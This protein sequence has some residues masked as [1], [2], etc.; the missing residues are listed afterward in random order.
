M[1][2]VV[3]TSHCDM[4]MRSNN[5]EWLPWLHEKGYEGAS[6]DFS[7]PGRNREIIKEYWRESV[8]QNRQFECCY[9]LG[10]R[11]IHDSGFNTEAFEKMPEDERQ[12]AQIGLL[13][14]VIDTQ[15]R[16]LRDVVGHPVMKIFVP[17]K[18]V[19]PLYDNGLKVPD[20]ITIVWANDNYGYVRRYPDETERVRSGGNGLY[21]HNSY[22]APPGASYTFLCSIPL[23]HTKNELRKAYEKGI[24]KLWVTNFGAIKP[25][26]M[27]ISFY[28][29]Y[30]WDI[31]KKRT[32]AY[33]AREQ[34]T[35]SGG[36][37]SLTE[38][39]QEW[40]A[41][42]IDRTF[43][44]AHGQVLAPILTAF[45]Q[46]TNTRKIEQMDDDAFSQTAYGNEAAMRIHLYEEWM[47]TAGAIFQSLPANERDAFYQ[48]VLMKIHAAYLTSL[49]YYYSDR[50]RL[51]LERGHNK[52]ALEACRS[53][54]EA[55]YARR[56]LFKYYN[57]VM[58]DGK[59]D[60]ILTPED[61]PPPRT[62][63]YPAC[64]PP[65]D[66]VEGD[67]DKC[68][69][70][71]ADY[72]CQGSRITLEAADG[73]ESINKNEP[74]PNCM[75]QSLK[76]WRII[77]Y[78]GRGRGSLAEATGE[79]GSLQYAFTLETDCAPL[80]ELHRF[81]S[82]NSVGRIYAEAAVDEE[83]PFTLESTATDEHR[84]SW[85]RN[86]RLGVDKLYVKLPHLKK[87]RHVLKIFG[88]S[89]YFAFSRI[90]LY[91]SERLE[92][93]LGYIE[94]DDSPVYAF[95]GHEF[96]RKWYGEECLSLTPRPVIIQDP[97][98][99]KDSTEAHDRYCLPKENAEPENIWRAHS[100]EE[101][102]RVEN[103]WKDRSDEEIVNFYQELIRTGSVPARETD[104]RILIETCAALGETENASYGNGEWTYCVSPAHQGRGLAMYIRGAFRTF[105]ED[106]SA[107]YLSFKIR[108]EG[109]Q[110]VIWLSVMTW[111]G[112]TD[113]FT[114]SVDGH[115]IPRD[116]LNEGRPLW[117]YS[118]E[119]VYKW[120]PVYE[121][122]LEKGIHELR[123]HTFATGMRIDQI[124]LQ[125]IENQ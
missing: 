97:R 6:Y 99:G 114:I 25:L 20:D 47:R 19:L 92:N 76:G 51:L 69:K 81:P 124:C 1:G 82:L 55:G 18:E 117:S 37:T 106:S 113:L 17:Y 46:L 43:S 42:W 70:T 120:I 102:I 119:Q 95:D 52:Q 4:L 90:V 78:T 63:M 38:D 112:N 118:G 39:V 111:M 105:P 107:P 101:G 8:E 88:A 85:S 67:E 32:S 31:G 122:A 65:R 83:H 49:M 33:D 61:F 53:S 54:E 30:A 23:A 24:R 125:R 75:G 14:E 35:L 21:Y 11:G 93:D 66:L 68:C 26:E 56:S 104:D 109:G 3:G 110:Y 2:I 36:G 121:T 45:D 74:L 100:D 123:F 15:N 84:G 91:A 13:Q 103:T 60:G 116:K 48:L 7:R 77:P 22:W 108:A 41:D 28:A 58:S 57:E 71:D 89:E 86:L 29:Q 27:Q 96:I 9:T 59:W 12:K 34:T 79:E 98:P 73:F 87:G 80:L 50:S 10:M 44:G 94:G 62:S 5:R 16:M 40:T 115:F 64:I 72:F